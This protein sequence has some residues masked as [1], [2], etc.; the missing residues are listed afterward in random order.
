MSRTTKIILASIAGLLL[1]CVVGVVGVFVLGRW[2]IGQAFTAD[3]TQAAA[4]GHQIATY[5]LPPGYAEVTAMNIAGTQ[6]VVIGNKS[7]A[8]PI[9]LLAQFA[10]TV[11]DPETMRRQMEQSM[12]QQANQQGVN[13]T[14]VNQEDV[15][16]KGETVTMTIREGTSSAGIQMRQEE[17]VFIGN[18][19]PAMVMIS[20]PV[21]DWD[22]DTIDKFLN[23]IR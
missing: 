21:N 12:Q 7:Q 8:G 9:I 3:P 20:G 22:K 16:I 10:S 1:V 13:F 23:S 19:G 5:D 14:S 6:M 11:S 18:K 4:L 2:A 17:G 15:T